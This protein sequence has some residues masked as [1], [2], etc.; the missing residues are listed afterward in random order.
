MFG[1]LFTLPTTTE[2]YAP[3]FEVMKFMFK[4]LSPLLIPIIGVMIFTFTLGVIIDR[5][6]Q[7]PSES[8][9]F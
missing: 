9:G 2:A 6:R 5:F 4:L 7:L 8:G 3:M 1:V